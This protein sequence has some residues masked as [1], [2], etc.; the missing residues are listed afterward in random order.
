MSRLTIGLGLLFVAMGLSTAAGDIVYTSDGSRLV[1]KVEQIAN[2][3]LII[4]TQ[5]AGRLEIDASKVTAVD[6]DEPVNIEFASGDKLVGIIEVSKPG[7]PA[8]AHTALGDIKVPSGQ[9]ASLWPKGT[10][11]P[12]I[13]AMQQQMEE[14][15]IAAEPKWTSKLEAGGVF[16]EGNTNTLNARG[17]ID[18]K[19]KTD[20]ELLEFFIAAQYSE[21]ETIRSKNEYMGGVRFEA[22]VNERKY[23]YT[24][25]GLEFDEF[26]KLDLRSTAAVGGGYYWLKKPDHEFKTSFGLGYRHETYNT[27][28]TGNSAV[29]D[30]GWRYRMDVSP[31]LQFTHVG[32]YSPDFQDTADYRLDVDT[33]V[34]LPFENPLWKL[35]VGMRNEYNSRPPSNTERLDNTIYANVVLTLK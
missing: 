9:I 6:T 15:R 1:G 24:R 22:S 17:R 35:K 31:T 3:K 23:W 4:V 18:V 7:E 29:V 34:I 28:L 32:T 21:Q 33:A 8:V 30:F 10:E 2:G 26:E 19:R 16:T 12:K 13:V 20:N 11:N 14:A 25:I 5:I 27:G